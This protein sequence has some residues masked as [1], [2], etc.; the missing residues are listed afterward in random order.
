MHLP[1]ETEEQMD[2]RLGDWDQ[3]FWDDP[4]QASLAS[5]I[6]S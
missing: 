5:L 3:E 6:L 4:E 1:P 2:K